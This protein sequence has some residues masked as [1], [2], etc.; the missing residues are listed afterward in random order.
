MIKWAEKSQ[1]MLSSNWRPR[2]AKDIIQSQFECLRIAGADDINPSP[3]REEDEMRCSSVS[4]EAK[5]G[6]GGGGWGG[7]FIRPLPFCSI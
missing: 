6:V 3:R 2:E 4:N 1:D 7:R 5:T